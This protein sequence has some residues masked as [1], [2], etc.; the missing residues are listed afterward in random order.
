MPFTLRIRTKDGMERLQTE[1][2]APLQSLRQQIAAQFGV[3]LEQQLLSRSEQTGPV[4]KKGAAF[5][6]AEEGAALSALATSSDT[7][8]RRDAAKA[9]GDLAAAEL[10]PAGSLRVADQLLSQGGLAVFLD[11]A[12]SHERAMQLAASR[13]LMHLAQRSQIHARILARKGA[14]RALSALVLGRDQVL[15][16]AVCAIH[17]TTKALLA[18][19]EPLSLKRLAKDAADADAAAARHLER[20]GAKIRSVAQAYE[21]AAERMAEYEEAER[22]RVAATAARTA[23]NLLK[24]LCS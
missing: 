4:A 24:H 19:R 3:P 17:A 11:A 13:G 21:Q 7:N 20:T 23:G 6:P 2:N 22:V 14:A 8:F 18:V 12:Y 15:T 5:G 9:L 16:N 1:P 10:D